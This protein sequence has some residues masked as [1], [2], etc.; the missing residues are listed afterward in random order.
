MKVAQAL[1][2]DPYECD[3]FMLVAGG[4]ATQASSPAA[5]DGDRARCLTNAP[6]PP[7]GIPSSASHVTAL[8]LHQRRGPAPRLRPAFRRNRG[9][10]VSPLDTVASCDGRQSGMAVG[11]LATKTSSLWP[12]EPR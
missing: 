3:P 12:S 10:A 7:P 11:E 1:G 4:G 2:I 6:P 5:M 8:A 9:Q